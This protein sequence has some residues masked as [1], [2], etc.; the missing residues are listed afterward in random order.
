MS[1]NMEIRAHCFYLDRSLPSPLAEF[2]VFKP[3]Q[4]AFCRLR[5]G[6]SAQTTFWASCSSKHVIWK[7]VIWGTREYKVRNMIWYCL[8]FTADDWEQARGICP[9]MQP[10]FIGF[11]RCDVSQILHFHVLYQLC[12]CVNFSPEIINSGNS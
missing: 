6:V 1:K 5:I 12:I 7:H 11:C 9:Q 8:L 4:R 10:C 2:Y 3:K